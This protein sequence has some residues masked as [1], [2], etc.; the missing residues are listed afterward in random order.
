MNE[1]VIKCLLHY[2]IHGHSIIISDVHHLFFSGRHGKS[3]T[4]KSTRLFNSTSILVDPPVSNP[5]RL[6]E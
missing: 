4:V 3:Y 5:T 2:R 1:K 6:Q